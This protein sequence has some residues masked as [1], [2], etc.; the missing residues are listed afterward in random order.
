MT[1]KLAPPFRFSIVCC[2]CPKGI[3]SLNFSDVDGSI[4]LNSSESGHL[5]RNTE[6]GDENVSFPR[7]ELGVI[8]ENDETVYRG[9]YPSLRNFT[10]LKRLG[11]S[12][13]ISLVKG[14]RDG[15]TLDLFQFCESEGITLV[16]VNV[17]SKILNKNVVS[18]LL[19]ILMDTSQLPA[20]IHC[21]D[22]GEST[23]TL[24]MCLRVLQKWSFGSMLSEYTRYV[25]D[26]VVS[27][28][29][30]NVVSSFNAEAVRFPPAS[31]LASWIMS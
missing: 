21:S 4:D 19:S 10:F 12:T 14:G 7:P 26:G 15:I 31:L 22:G 25:K 6:E 27:S 20:Y 29:V 8:D 1:N 16:I 28:G 9:G 18:E 3:D 5:T 30:K 17:E 23:G 2:A 11:L 24:V 13:I